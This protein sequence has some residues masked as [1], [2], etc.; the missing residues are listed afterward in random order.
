MAAEIGLPATAVSREL[1]P[2]HR[3]R[4]GWQRSASIQQW[5][6]DEGHAFEFHQAVRLL[7]LFGADRNPVAQGTDA[8]R[9]AVRFRSAM[10]N[11]FP[12]S[13]VEG[14]YDLAAP[15]MV[16]RFLALAGVCGPLPHPFTELLQQRLR[17]GDTALRDFLDLFHHRLVS[18]F[19]RTRRQN[20]LGLEPGSPETHRA[21]AHLYALLGLGTPSLRGRMGIADRALLRYAGLLGRSSRSLT[22]LEVLL[23][24]FLGLP[25]CSRP[26][27]GAWRELD[28]VSWTRLAADEPSPTLGRG[29]VLGTRVW[30][31]H[32]GIELRIGPLQ[33]S[34]FLALLPGGISFVAMRDLVRFYAGSQ[35]L[36][37]VDLLL[38]LHPGEARATGLSA[39]TGPRLGFTSWLSAQER[40]DSAVELRLSTAIRVPEEGRR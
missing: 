31:D 8:A 27:L 26:F 25:I 18:I 23:S 11:G 1:G 21:A 22:G 40:I 29:A 39:E 9:E 38:V 17:V 12:A 36:F 37:D 7:E 35:S 5:L 15:I 3:P 14:V 19:Y 16:V 34:Q 4:H 24:D 13:D 28:P 30:D 6:F 10:D 2:L 32:A 33:Y 20:R